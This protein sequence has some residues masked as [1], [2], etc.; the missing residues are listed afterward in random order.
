MISANDEHHPENAF[1]PF[2]TENRPLIKRIAFNI[3][4]MLR[5]MGNVFIFDLRKIT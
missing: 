1:W 2:V 3:S 4:E 5:I